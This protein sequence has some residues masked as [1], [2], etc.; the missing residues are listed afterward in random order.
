MDDDV[1]PEARDLARRCPCR[2]AAA[3]ARPEHPQVRTSRRAADPQGRARRARGAAGGRPAA[4]AACPRPAARSWSTAVAGCSTVLLVGGAAFGLAPPRGAIEQSPQAGVRAGNQRGARSSR[5]TATSPSRPSEPAPAAAIRRRR[6]RRPLRRRPRRPRPPTRAAPAHPVGLARRPR[7]ASRTARPPAPKRCRPRCRQARS[8]EIQPL[9]RPASDAPAAQRQSEISLRF[10]VG[11]STAR[12]ARSRCC[13]TAVA[14]TPLGAC[15][16]RVGRKH[17]PSQPQPA[18]VTFRIPPTASRLRPPRRARP[19]RPVWRRGFRRGPRQ[20]GHGDRVAAVLG[21]APASLAWAP[22]HVATSAAPAASRRRH[23][24]DRVDPAAPQALGRV[25]AAGPTAA[26]AGACLSSGGYGYTE[27]GAE[28]PATP[29]TARRAP[30][31][32]EGRPADRVARASRLRLDGRYDRHHGR[33]GRRRRL[34]RRSPPLRPRR[35]GALRRRAPRRRPPRA[36]GLPGRAAPSIDFSAVTPELSGALTWAPR[37]TP[38]WLTATGGYR[39]NR[40]ARTAGDISRLSASDRL[41]LE[42][43]AFDQAIMGL[44]A[45]YGGGRAQGFVEVSAEMM[46]G[47]GAPPASES[48]VRAGGGIRL[49]LNDDVRL[50]DRVEAV[51]GLA[52]RRCRGRTAGAR[53]AARGRLARRRLSLRGRQPSSPPRLPRRRRRR[54]RLGPRSRASAAPGGWSPPTATRCPSRA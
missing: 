46:V 48:P 49:A 31:R 7:G 3:P 54:S 32:V 37:G 11:R 16:A 43:S 22:A 13:P 25:H 30:S 14:A 34:D 47:A 28:Q 41:G 36:V 10:D 33:A 21:L 8:A 51:L 52:P 44:G 18:P 12:P 9:L 4:A 38:F 50:E 17:R 6:W 27:V 24:R 53:A 39:L 42:L 35:I 2:P 1:R 23:R 19:L 20:Q 26:R 29:T 45:A 15:L 5:K 40:S